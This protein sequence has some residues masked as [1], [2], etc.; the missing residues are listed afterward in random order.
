M[1]KKI[2]IVQ[3][4]L[5]AV[6]IQ[7]CVINL[8]DSVTGNGNVVEETRY[9]DD[10]VSLRVSNGL[11]VYLTQGTEIFI[12][13]E[14]DEN[15]LEHIKTDIS[16]KELKIYS[17]VS[18]R[19]AKSKKI[20]LGYRNLNEIHISSAGDVKGENTL[21]TDELKIRLSSA[22]DLKLDV[23]AEEVDIDISSSGNALLSGRTGYL[24]A[25]LSSAGDLNAFNLEAEKADVN[26]SSAGDAKVFVTGEAR[27]KSSSAGDIVYKGN[28]EILEM[29]SSSAGDIRKG[30]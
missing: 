27:F 22:G 3:I 2:N 7:G 1:I 4:S 5:L 15:L 21:H 9:A 28:P 29:N 16:G 17:D 24:H 8:G 23:I 12:K 13:L 14:V 19:M 10:F 30:K 26:V 18:I 11:D 6:I 20:Y 25:S